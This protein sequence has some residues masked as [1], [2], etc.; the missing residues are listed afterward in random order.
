[1]YTSGFKVLTNKNLKNRGQANVGLCNWSYSFVLLCT[2][3]TNHVKR[4][5]KLSYTNVKCTGKLSYKKHALTAER[6]FYIS[7]EKLIYEENPADIA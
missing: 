6:T 2:A 4:T 3:R 1:M 5:G 7:S